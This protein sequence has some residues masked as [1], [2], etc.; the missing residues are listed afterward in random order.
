MMGE[1]SLA[2]WG[3]KSHKNAHD[4][5]KVDERGMDDHFRRGKEMHYEMIDL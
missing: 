1:M 4:I 2:D 5:D 3:E